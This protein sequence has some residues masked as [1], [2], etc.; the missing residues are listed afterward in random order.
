MPRQSDLDLFKA[1]GIRVR[2]AR[3]AK[4]GMTQERLAELVNVEPQTI[5]NL[6]NGRHGASLPVL[7]SIADALEVSLGDLVDTDRPQPDV[8][9]PAKDD[10][11][12]LWDRMSDRQR[13]AALRVAREIVAL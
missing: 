10:W 2:G 6:E 12:E 3:V 13:W 11:S 5:S 9:A 4:K 7:A 8:A 1:I